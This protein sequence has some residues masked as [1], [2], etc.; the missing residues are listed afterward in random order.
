MTSVGVGVKEIRIHAGGEFRMLYVAKFE[1]A[2]YVLH[3]FTKKSQKTTGADIE[4]ARGRLR[5]LVADR[6]RTS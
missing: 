2:I 5:A 4:I 3:A 6:R 1:E